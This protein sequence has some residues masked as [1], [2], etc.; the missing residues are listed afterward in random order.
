MNGRSETP[1]ALATR[2]QHRAANPT[3]SAWVSASAGSGKTQVLRDRVLRLLL[4]GAAPERI[5]CLTFTKAGASEMSNRIATTLAEWASMPD[6]ALK[7]QLKSLAGDGGLTRLMG[8]ARGLF[9]KVLDAPGG[10]RIETIHAFCQSL[11]RRFPLEARV[12]PHFRL[13]EERDASALLLQARESQLNAARLGSDPGLSAALAHAVQRTGETGIDNI[14]GELLRDRARFSGFTRRM[15]DIDSYR[16][17]LAALLGIAPDE[18]RRAVLEAAVG[19]AALNP[20]ALRAAM[21]ALLQ[22]S[23]TDVD[24]AA[25][26]DAFLASDRPGRIAAFDSYLSV[27]LTATGEIRARLATKGA[28]LAIPTVEEI[29]RAEAGRLTLVLE[30]LRAIDILVDSVALVTLGRDLFTRFRQLKDVTAALDFDDLILASRD[31]LTQPGI[32]PWVL[33]KL[34]G[35]IDHVLIDEGQDTSPVQW[36]IIKALSDELIAGSGADRRARLAPDTPEKPRSIFA[37]GDFKQ[38]IFSFQ[39]AEPRAF[40]GAREHFRERLAKSD[41]LRDSRT[42]FE[43]VPLIVSFRSGPAVLRVVDQV[44]AG[45]AGAGVVESSGRIQHVPARS[46]AAGLVEVWPRA[47]PL[48]ATPPLAWAPPSVDTDPGDPGSRVANAIADK[49]AELV[50]GNTPLEA[51]GRPITAGDIM[52]L[53]RSRNAFVPTLVK[54]LKARQVDVSGIDRLALL[55]ELAVRDLVA[56]IDFLLLPED[57]LTLAA[58]LKSPLVGLTEDDLFTLCVARG[59]LALWHHLARLNTTD[60]R[61]LAARDFLQGYLLRAQSLTP[62]E[63]LADVLSAGGGRQNLFARL[64]LQVGEAIEEL[65]NLA[66]LYESNNLASLQGF[67]QWLEMGE[68]VVKRELTE[69]GGGQVRIMTVHGAK[70][71]QAPIVFV[72]DAQ[73][74]KPNRPGLFWLGVEG[75]GLPVWVQRRELDVNATAAAR[76]VLDQRG[77]EEENRLLYVALTRAE[78]RLYVCGWRG[79]SAGGTRSWHD[80]V[81]DALQELDGTTSLPA[82]NWRSE[83]GWE[84]DWRSYSHQQADPPKAK[85][86][87]AGLPLDLAIPLPPWAQMA[88]SAEPDPPRPLIPS[89]PSTDAASGGEVALLSPLGRDQGFRFQRGLMIHKLFQLLPDLPLAER[90]AAALHWLQRVNRP[91]GLLAEAEALEDIVDEVMAVLEHETFAPLFVPG[92]RAEVPI[93]A[94]LP[95]A[96]GGREILSGQIDRL[97]VTTDT[98]HIIDFKS[99]RPPAMQPEHVSRQYLRQL[100]LYKSAVQGIY[101]NH[102]VSCYLLWSAVP[103]LMPIPDSLLE[104]YA[105]RANDGPGRLA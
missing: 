52:V 16:R 87:K 80:S 69:D 82:A 14:V 47:V 40:L 41:S 88:A 36:D 51:Q 99:N 98:C 73:R 29:L 23:K 71:L 18:D 55:S 30:Q 67:R 89:R 21:A 8:V 33:Y 64:G 74:R 25:V 61:L 90:H 79:R 22:G 91:S 11:L 42:P 78:D 39:G 17:A 57:D 32:A 100:A 104:S 96:D 27:F 35:G 53:V 65:L 58:L 105:F 31:L 26:L 37:V 24:R 86:A 10:M 54:A 50:S 75:G 68:A 56:M 62:Y 46:G 28:V 59:D 94:D 92:S 45:D 34:D 3:V 13:I 1:T 72:A 5:L 19:D 63:L 95:G 101:P 4:E 84:G 6:G 60:A 77:L 44:F 97:V 70:G 85:S 15:A 81:A 2:E 76:A 102:T 43:D 93:V 38:S 7:E 103:R 48:E 83:A 66:L 20:A 12:A 9:A 49:I